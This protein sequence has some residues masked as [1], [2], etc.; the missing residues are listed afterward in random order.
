MVV[1]NAA[2]TGKLGN[3]LGS[4]GTKNMNSFYVIVGTA[5]KGVHF[6]LK[7]NL[8]A[9]QTVLEEKKISPLLILLEHRLPSARLHSA[10]T[11]FISLPV[12][13]LGG[14]SLGK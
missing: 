11:E 10:F 2:T 4:N 8:A 3:N 7:L 14:M 1:G 5:Y 6:M 9:F 13:L 12:Y